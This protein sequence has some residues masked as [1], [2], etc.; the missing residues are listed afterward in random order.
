MRIVSWNV[1]SIRARLEQVL[2]FC[3]EQQPDVLALQET[4]VE[5]ADF[6]A[7]PFRALGYELVLNGQ[8]A[9]NGVA[10]LARGPLADPCLALADFP[11][12]Q[13]RFLAVTFGDLRLINVYV[14]NG[15][16][17]GSDKYAYKL[18]WLEALKRQLE[19]ELA[20]H[21][22]LIV[23]GD[24]NVA[25]D[26]RDVH[27]PALWQGQIHCSEPERAA[28]R[29]IM[30]IGL[31]DAFRRL[32]PE[33]RAFSWWDYRQGAFRRDMGLRIDLVLLS[34]ALLPRLVAA[35][36]AREVRAWE[37]PSDHAPVWIE[38]S[39]ESA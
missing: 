33:A 11:D 8:R 19:A 20:L 10:L 31:I 32:H 28:L 12:P 17:V 21:P 35:G 27:D 29:A 6:P 4:K 5:D 26:D 18:R 16:E 25:P 14:V 34:E 15:Q 3:S 2:R 36:I 13:R 39:A 23:L 38:L 7:E 37:K 30:A 9:Y 24:F 1:N 22:R